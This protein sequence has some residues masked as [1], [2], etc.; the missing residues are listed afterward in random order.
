MKYRIDAACVHIAV[1]ATRRS[2]GVILHSVACMVACAST[3]VITTW[4]S[5]GVVHD[6]MMLDMV[7][8]MLFIACLLYHGLCLQAVDSSREDLI[9]NMCIHSMACLKHN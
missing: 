7:V 4:H 1:I 3:A 8:D 6:C 5:A 2:T 9:V